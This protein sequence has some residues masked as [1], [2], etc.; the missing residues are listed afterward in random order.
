MTDYDELLEN[1][2]QTMFTASSLLANV[3][4]HEGAPKWIGYVA[5]LYACIGAFLEK[6]VNEELLLKMS[7]VATE[8]IKSELVAMMAA[9]FGASP[10]EGYEEWLKNG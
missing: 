7:Y 2:C 4:T 3:S 9:E 10:P 6:P 1:T 5:Y 8:L